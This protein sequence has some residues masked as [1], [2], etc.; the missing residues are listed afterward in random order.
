MS[1]G[2]SHERQLALGHRVCGELA[3]D[4]VE[5][6][7]R[8]AA[9]LE[10]RAVEH[11]QQGGAALDVPQELQAEA[12][13]LARAL[14]EAR[15]VGD[16]VAGFARVDDAEVRVQGRERVVGD[17]R[18]GGA[19]RRDET[20]LARGRVADESDVGDGLELEQD[21]PL[22]SGRAQQR[23]SGRLA[24][25]GGQ[26]RVAESALAARSDDEAHA[27]GIQVDE[28]VAVGRAHDGA[29]GHA[30]LEVLS[31]G[32]VA[33]VAHAGLAV[34]GLPVRGA[35]EAEQCRH[36]RVG[37]E[38]DVAAVAAVAAVGAGERL[39]LLALDR[40]AAVAA[41]ARAQVEGHVVD[42]CRH[43]RASCVKRRQRAE[44]RCRVT[45]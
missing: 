18:L 11:V 42:E 5:V 25:G 22:E 30:Q 19:H 32:A 35:V 40:D 21:V 13:A 4:H 38:H 24:L 2:R 33:V 9:G 16:G 23:E 39:E 34:V 28:F 6:A 45:R 20:R 43:G 3:E 26:R 10:G 12:L 41:V 29:D 37:D 7:D 14:D 27:R 31:G 17:L 36:L 8:V 44:A 1:C 15:H